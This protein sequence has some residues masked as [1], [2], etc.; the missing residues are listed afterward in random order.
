MTFD[1]CFPFKLAEIVLENSEKEE[2]KGCVFFKLQN[3]ISM[4]RLP[5][6]FLPKIMLSYTYA[7][8][9][10][11]DGLGLGF[12]STRHHKVITVA[13]KR[14]NNNNNNSVEVTIKI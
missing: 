11:R 8:I 12:N 14:Y 13:L 5:E 10:G 9:T 7:A 1:I 2:T 3:W 4:K 6:W